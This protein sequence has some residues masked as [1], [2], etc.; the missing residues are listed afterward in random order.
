M[1]LIQVTLDFGRAGSAETPTH[2]GTHVEDDKNFLD[3]YNAVTGK[4]DQ[5][6]SLTHGQTEFNVFKA[7]AEIDHEHGFGPNDTQ[8][9][10]DFLHDSPT[11]GPI[12][13][14]PV[15]DPARFPTGEPE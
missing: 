5:S 1:P 2:E 9:I 14:V 7:G 13:D 3:S 6:L 8:K 4:Y 15:F 11:Y 10:L 12:F